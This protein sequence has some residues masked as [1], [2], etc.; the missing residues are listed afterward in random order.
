MKSILTRLFILFCTITM[1]A[2]S[3][4]GQVLQDSVYT[5]AEI[6]EDLDFLK[7]ALKAV[8]PALYEYQTEEEVDALFAKAKNQVKERMTD[9]DMLNLIG[10]IAKNIGCGHTSVAKVSTK[11]ERKIMKKNKLNSLDTV[12][13]LPF[14]GKIIDNQFFVG[15]SYDSTLLST[16]EITAIDNHEPSELWEKMQTYP[17]VSEDGVSNRLLNHYAKTGILKHVY[18][19]YYPVG[20]SIQLT[21][22]KNNRDSTYFTKTYNYKGLPSFPRQNYNQEEWQKIALGKEKAWAQGIQLYKHAT[23]KGVMLLSLDSFKDGYAKRINKAFELVALHR[24]KTL[25][26]DLRGNLGGNM[27]TMTTLLAK[28]LSKPHAIRMSK[29]EFPKAYR[30]NS[31]NGFFLA[32]VIRGLNFFFFYKKRKIN[33]KTYLYKTFKPAKEHLYKGDFMVLIDGGSF[34]AASLYAAIIQNDNRATFFG[35]ETGGAKDVNNA[36]IFYFPK[37][38]NSRCSF[39]IPRYRMDHQLT[40]ENKGRGVMP[41]YEVKETVESFKKGEDLVLQ[42]VMEVIGEEK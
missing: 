12:R 11:A 16:L 22:K 23:K 41:D 9:W 6:I 36:A 5:K 37:L 38:P 1:A 25:I 15:N 32:P 35:E 8:H 10:P 29:K 19:Y 18:R 2:N 39:R 24:T 17:P 3:A 27:K 28:T 7:G 42:K 40:A 14:E 20:D 21:I 33:N 26:L 13:F 34:S 31:H 30:K 4:S